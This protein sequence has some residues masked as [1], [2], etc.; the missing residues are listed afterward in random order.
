MMRFLLKITLDRKS[1]PIDYRRKVMSYFKTALKGHEAGKYY[2]TFYGET[3]EKGFSFGV[4]LPRACFKQE[5]VELSDNKINIIFATP[6]NGHGVAFFNCFLNLKNKS[7]T[8]GDNEFTLT[9]ICLARERLINKNAADFKITSPICLRCHKR[10][11]NKDF[12]VS[13]SA[14]DFVAVLK[15]DIRRQLGQY[16]PSL[17]QYVDALEVNTDLCKK[18]VVRHYNQYIEATVGVIGFRGEAI[19][20]NAIQQ[21]NLGHRKGAGFGLLTL[22]T[23][24]EVE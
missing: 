23:Q 1:L 2:P 11:G 10:E 13:V 15:E 24:E 18:T 21:M 8:V 4:I 7:I 19:L 17:T 22:M 16:K 12:Y 3:G 20:L 5:I 6:N 14:R 9:D